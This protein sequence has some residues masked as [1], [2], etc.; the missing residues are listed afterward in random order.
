METDIEWHAWKKLLGTAVHAGE[1]LGV[2]E[3]NIA[4]L[5]YRIGGVLAD[6]FDP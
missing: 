5:A 1:A 6:H 2:S 4:D 3:K